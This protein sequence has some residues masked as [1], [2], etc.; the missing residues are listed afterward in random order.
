M[1]QGQIYR[2]WTLDHA[3]VVLN[4]HHKTK[5]MKNKPNNNNKKLITKRNEKDHDI[6]SK[7]KNKTK[8]Q[9]PRLTAGSV[10]C[11]T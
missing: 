11:K 4:Y 3:E 10:N 2:N 6:A 9:Q 8:K 1:K 5:H 7:A